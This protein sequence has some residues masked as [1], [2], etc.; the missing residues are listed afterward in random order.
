VGELTNE[1]RAGAGLPPLAWDDGLA[2]VARRHAEDLA[3]RGVVAHVV[4]GE[5]PLDRV[6][7]GGYPAAFVGENL[8]RAYPVAADPTVADGTVIAWMNSPDHR[9]NLLDVEPTQVGVG[10]V[11][12]PIPVDGVDVG[13]RDLYVVQVLARPAR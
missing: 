5:T 6:L 1:V 13:L 4:D 7:D 2:E 8:F 12:A 9:A 10:V 11:L 3:A